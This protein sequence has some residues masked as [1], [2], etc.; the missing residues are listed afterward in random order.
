MDL[1]TIE[2]EIDPYYCSE[3]ESENC[4]NTKDDNNIDGEDNFEV[5]K[6]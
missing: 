1:K 4:E 6:S 5:K 2:L 3:F